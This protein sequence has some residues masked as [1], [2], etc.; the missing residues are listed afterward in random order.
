MR[1][2]S[3]FA[4]KFILQLFLLLIFFIVV[5]TIKGDCTVNEA[6][7]F[8]YRPDVEAFIEHMHQ[9]YKMNP[10]EL[11]D[12]FLQVSPRPRALKT[13][14][15]PIK[16]PNW[17]YY[18]RSFLTINRI[19]QGV[20]FWHHY[21]SILARASKMYG[22]PEKI[23]VAI[24]G[25]ESR[26]GANTGRYR[27]I[28]SLSTFAFNDPNRS[29]YFRHELAQF[30]LFSKEANLDPLQIQ[31]SWDG[32]LGWPQFMPSSARRYAVD[33]NH[34]GRR[35]IL[36]S[37]EDAIGSVANYF[38]QQGWQ[39]WAPVAIPAIVKKNPPKPVSGTLQSLEL[40]G[41]R[42][43]TRLPL[44][45]DTPVKLIIFQT[46]AGSEYWLGFH[47]LSLLHEYNHSLY[48]AMV[49]FELANAIQASYKA[50]YRTIK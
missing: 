39:T 7:T 15:Q 4:R 10:S 44:P 45:A 43:N 18:Q 31:G 2:G 17:T 40:K 6:G 5:V 25:M 30:L 48:Y 34:D 49:T 46:S 27:A 50:Q 21:Q 20:S 33:M 36:N 13:A 1:P 47:N 35:D 32:A 28:D 23:I 9:K 8:A 29:R 42:I 26:Y 16:S 19:N 12:L 37:P 41:I 11:H 3:S 22:V 38:H 14:S 24:L